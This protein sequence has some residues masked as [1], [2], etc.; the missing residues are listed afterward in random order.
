M[1]LLHDR[2]TLVFFALCLCSSADAQSWNFTQE[3]VPEELERSK[4][5]GYA[6]AMTDR[7]MLISALGE[8]KDEQGHDSI[9]GAGAVYV[10]YRNDDGVWQFN[11][12]LV[13]K[14][15]DRSRFNQFG[16]SIVADGNLAVTAARR[17]APSPQ[18][19]G[20][21]LP[22]IVY[23][24]ELQS[25]NQWLEKHVLLPYDGEAFDNFGE[26][27]AIHQDRII[28]GAPF[29]KKRRFAA[30]PLI[31]IGAA[32]IFERDDEGNWKQVKKMSPAGLETGN[33]FGSSVAIHGNFAVVG[34]PLHS[35]DKNNTNPKIV[36]GAAYVYQRD[37]FGFWKLIQKLTGPDRSQGGQFGSSIAMED[38]YLIIGAAEHPLDDRGESFMRQTGAAYIYKL[39]ENDEW[40]FVQKIV[41][42]DREQ[43]DGASLFGAGV[44]IDL[45]YV[46]VTAQFDRGRN[47]DGNDVGG[48]YVFEQNNAGTWTEVHRIKAREIPDEQQ[49]SPRSLIHN[50]SLVAVSPT[51]RF[52]DNDVNRALVGSVYVFELNGPVGISKHNQVPDVSLFPNPGN[53]AVVLEIPTEAAYQQLSI[54][55]LMGQEVYQQSVIGQ[56]EVSLDIQGSSG[57]YLI[58]LVTVDGE[59]NSLK[60]IKQ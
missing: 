45:P 55:N 50:Q 1:R 13:E 33:Q 4:Q 47:M 30:P 12:K 57:V 25:N 60:Y 8:T 36:A 42:S 5:F 9:H 26:E 56:S 29:A 17:L 41:A 28:V 27:I 14:P 18:E 11:Q 37:E 58:S 21:E 10:Y 48:L 35:L 43:A 59:R 22:G 19:P 40:K 23:V 39:D 32:Y 51:E 38:G 49:F 53:G 34:T 6:A 20:P 16:K 15:E 7:H 3:I 31:N 2:I 24:Y 46:M 52:I 44:S 54:R